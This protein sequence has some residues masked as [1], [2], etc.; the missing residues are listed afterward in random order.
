MF[1]PWAIQSSQVFFETL[2]T[3]AIVNLKPLVPGHVLVIPKRVEP[4]LGN[5]SPD[6]VTDLFQSVY[7]IQPVLERHYGT[8]ACNIAIQ[9]GKDAGQ[10]VPHVHVHI[11]PRRRGDFQRNDDIYDQL[12]KKDLGAEMCDKNE[13]QQ[14]TSGGGHA[15]PERRPRSE[16][17]MAAEAATLRALFPDNTP[18]DW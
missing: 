14:K 11:L 4:R 15:E 1:G 8:S 13:H 17:E 7:K 6:E 12:E 9:D 3:R 10:S 2:S 5:L 18:V 16:E